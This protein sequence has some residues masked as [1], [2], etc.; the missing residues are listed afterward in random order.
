MNLI[1][2]A[3]K[4]YSGIS[5]LTDW[6]GSGGHTV[7]IEI[8]Q[9]RADT[10]LNCK[11]SGR[12][13]LVS[14]SAAKVLRSVI[15]IKNGSNLRVVG[16]KSLGSCGVCLCKLNLKIWVPVFHIL[17]AMDEEELTRFPD[18]CWIKSES[19]QLN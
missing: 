10:C 3:K 2:E 9:H 19:T 7:P 8:A 11:Y 16:E 4:Y 13:L 1:E 17:A 12:S 5:I 15:E 6:L 18:G 14:G